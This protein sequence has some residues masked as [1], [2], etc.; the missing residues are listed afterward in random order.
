VLWVINSVTYFMLLPFLLVY[1]VKVYLNTAKNGL[2][3][4]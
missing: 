3:D 1:V 2:H 4:R